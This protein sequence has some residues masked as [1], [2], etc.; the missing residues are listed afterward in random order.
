MVRSYRARARE[1]RDELDFTII[2]RIEGM[3][4]KTARVLQIVTRRREGGNS[5]YIQKRTDESIRLC[6]FLS[7]VLGAPMGG[8]SY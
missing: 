1:A 8:K 3:L 6:V 7:Y 4:L 5:Q 2:E